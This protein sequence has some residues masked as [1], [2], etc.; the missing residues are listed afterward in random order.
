MMILLEGPDLSG[1]STLAAELAAHRP[2]KVPFVTTEHYGPPG[3]DPL[4]EYLTAV[5]RARQRYRRDGTVTIFDRLHLGQ[6]TYG[7]VCRGEKDG[8]EWRRLLE[9]LMLS[10]G[11]VLVPCYLSEEKFLRAWAHPTGAH[12]ETR[13]T[14]M[15]EILQRYRHLFDGAADASGRPRNRTFLPMTDPYDWTLETRQ[16][17]STVRDRT[18]QRIWGRW[19][20]VMA[21]RT[22]ADPLA[23]K[24]PFL[25]S[26]EAR[27]W[28]VG[29][30]VRA[31]SNEQHLSLPF[32]QRT[33][34]GAMLGRACRLARVHERDLAFFNSYGEDDLP[35]SAADVQAALGDPPK[36]VVLLGKEAL[37][38][39]HAYTP[40][41]RDLRFLPHP[42]YVRRFRHHLSRA[43]VAELAG[44][45]YDVHL[46]ARRESCR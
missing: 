19:K 4:N 16:V 5:L 39:W 44:H 31:S 35:T 14:R 46:Q 27:C 9:R 24:F 43:W 32:F 8:M 23:P 28:V 2:K 6:P 18:L 11:A 33:G 3:P 15:W 21:A 22:S 45:L 42:S 12:Y 13:P 20:G 10:L 7:V 41:R 37:H 34:S 25:G 26:P 38:W 1:K 29:D 30:R 17:H 40:W 36:R